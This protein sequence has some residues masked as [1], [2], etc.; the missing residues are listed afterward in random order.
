MR[1]F[2]GREAVWWNAPGPHGRF[3]LARPADVRRAIRRF[4]ELGAH[5]NPTSVIGP[6]TNRPITDDDY[7]A[8]DKVGPLALPKRVGRLA[9]MPQAPAQREVLNELNRC[10]RDE[11]MSRGT[12][13]RQIAT[14]CGS[15]GF[16]SPQ[17]RVGSDD[18]GHVIRRALFMRRIALYYE[19]GIPQHAPPAPRSPEPEMY[20]GEV[21]PEPV[22]FELEVEVSL[23]EF[24]TDNDRFSVLPYPDGDFGQDR[25]FFEIETDVK[26]VRGSVNDTIDSM[27]VTVQTEEGNTLYE[28]KFTQ[29]SASQEQSKLLKA[30]DHR[31]AWDGYN[32]QGVLDTR[33]LRGRLSLK[34]EIEKQ[35]KRAEDTLSLNNEGDRHGK[36]YVEAR[37]DR[38]AKKVEVEVFL[39]P[40]DAKRGQ[41][42]ERVSAL[43]AVGIGRHWSRNKRRSLGKGVD[44]GGTTFEVSTRASFR[45]NDALEMRL[46][47]DDRPLGDAGRSYNMGADN[48]DGQAIIPMT[49]YYLSQHFFPEVDFQHTAA[50]EFGHSVLRARGGRKFS[51]EHKG[52]STRFGNL[53]D[54]TPK[55]PTNGEIDLMK[56]YVTDLSESDIK[57]RSVASGDDVRRLISLAEVDFDA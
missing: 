34:V 41:N 7:P 23:K 57:V 55:L 5:E 51:W 25:V 26:R 15:N 31:W 42:F 38:G 45:G 6:Y 33:V 56:Y 49:V 29:H 50:H 53:I 37:V 36:D 22:E 43:A 40:F 16:E 46:V 48:S 30:G 19:P 54:R 3:V 21:I 47:T 27:T 1:P 52:T 10:I 11:T 12:H 13:H 9:L 8:Y 39:N 35:G 44:V 17:E 14:L 32:H 18:Q 4:P 24:R 20:A 28:E 2:L